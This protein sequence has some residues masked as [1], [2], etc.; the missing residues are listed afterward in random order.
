MSLP[1]TITRGHCKSNGH[2]WCDLSRWWSRNQQPSLPFKTKSCFTPSLGS[3]VAW[4]VQFVTSADRGIA[5]A[6]YVLYWKV[7]LCWYSVCNIRYQHEERKLFLMTDNSVFTLLTPSGILL[8]MQFFP[9]AFFFLQWIKLFVLSNVWI[10]VYLICL[11]NFYCYYL[12][13]I[14]IKLCTALSVWVFLWACS[15]RHRQ[16]ARRVNHKTI[17][18]SPEMLP[19]CSKINPVELRLYSNR[20][21]IGEFLT[22]S[23]HPALSAT[24]LPACQHS[25]ECCLSGLNAELEL[26]SSAAPRVAMCSF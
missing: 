21:A 1:Q 3:W 6:C 18:C 23:G 19:A 7:P 4:S 12:F 8:T 5:P 10:Q 17:G 14:F 11:Y 16:S 13:A 22:A 25:K 24:F 2:T 15:K 9:H 26:D 20:G